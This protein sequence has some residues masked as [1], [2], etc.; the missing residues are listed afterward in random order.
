MRCKHIPVLN[1]RMYLLGFREIF[2]PKGDLAL[3]NS[4]LKSSEYT[5]M[6]TDGRIYIAEGVYQRRRAVIEKRAEHISQPYG[7]LP[8]LRALFSSPGR[9]VGFVIS[10]LLFLLLSLPVWDVRI[11]GFEGLD[12][13]RV[14]RALKDG[15]VYSGALSLGINEGR[16]ETS[17]LA[18]CSD[19]GWISIDRRGY[20]VYVKCLPRVDADLPQSH[21]YSNIVADRDCVIEQISVTGGKAEVRVGQYVRAGEILISGIIES[22]SGTY[23]CEAEGTVLGRCDKTVT[24]SVP[25]REQVI[26]QGER[27]LA[28]K[29]IGIFN[30]FINIFKNYGN[31]ETDYAII[32]ENE[33]LHLKDGRKLPI[34]VR[35]VYLQE[36][37]YSI[38][39]Y[40]DGRMALLAR[41]RLA[42]AVGEAVAGAQTVSMTSSFRFEGDMCHGETKLVLVTEIGCERLIVTEE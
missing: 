18:G 42:L 28:E 24:V 33:Y 40:D 20:A 12:E 6:L 1:L 30:F 17:V 34:S 11:E 21:G 5:L 27:R 35:R 31:Y 41:E 15:G 8:R 29:S 36:R 19:V 2:L 23:F 10:L 3:I 26:T 9:V 37:E 38:M 4:S 22:E 32:E 7:L 39:E 16:A 25:R 13:E 14:L